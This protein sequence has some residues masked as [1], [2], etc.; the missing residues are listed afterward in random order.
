MSIRFF[1]VGLIA[2]AP[3]ALLAHHSTGLYDMSKTMTVEAPL[4]DVKWGYPHITA[5]VKS[6]KKTWLVTFPPTT[7]MARTEVT[8]EKL[9]SARSVKIVG[10][11]RKDGKKEIRVSSLTLDGKKK[12]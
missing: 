2:A 11:P 5:K 10:N 7:A 6:Q 8:R 4:T 1:I 3:A 9:I 12:W